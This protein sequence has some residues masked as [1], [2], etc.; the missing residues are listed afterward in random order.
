MGAMPTAP[1]A[2]GYEWLA[3]EQM[4][5]VRCRTGVCRV[6]SPAVPERYGL[7][8]ET[9]RSGPWLTCSQLI[10]TL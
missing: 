5:A 7:Q 10:H 2:K 4:Q 3:I 8:M 9:S 1:R 6:P